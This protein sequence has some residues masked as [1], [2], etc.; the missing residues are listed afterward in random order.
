MPL[1]LLLLSLELN[2]N[3]IDGTKPVSTVL[4]HSVEL[5]DYGVQFNSKVHDQSAN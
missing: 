4:C 5:E 3:E 1:H 2:Y